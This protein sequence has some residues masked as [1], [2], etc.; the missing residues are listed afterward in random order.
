[1]SRVCN[2]Y[3]T[4]GSKFSCILWFVL[5][6]E[7]QAGLC[8]DR[9]RSG[10]ALPGHLD[11]RHSPRHARLQGGI[12]ARFPARRPNREQL[13]LVGDIV[14][15]WQLQ[16]SWYWPQSH[17]DVVQK[18]LRKARKGTEVIY[19]PGNHDEMLRRL[20]R[21]CS[22][23]GVQVAD[24][25]D[26]RDRRRPAAAGDPRRPVRRHR[27][28][29]AL[30]RAS[31][32]TRAYNVTLAAQPLLQ[33]RAPAARLS[34]LVAVG[35]PEAQGQERGRV[36]STDFEDAVADEAR[37]RGVDGVVCG[38]IHH[39]RDPRHRR[40]ALLQRRRLGRELHRAGRASRRA[41]RDH[42]TGWISARSIRCCA[43]VP[44]A[45]T[46]RRPDARLRIALVSDA[47]PPQINGVVR[48]LRHAGRRISTPPA[49]AVETMTPDRFRTIP[50]PSYPEIR[51][52]LKP[53]RRVARADRR[54]RAATP[55]TSPP[56][57]RSAWRR[58]ALCLKRGLPFTT[59]FH[60]AFPEYVAAR[61]A[62]PIAWG[63]AWLRRFHAPSH[64]VH[65]GHRDRAP[66]SRRPRLREAPALGPR[67][68]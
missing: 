13:Y 2:R 7:L 34:L 52:A 59:A 28:L 26:P 39:R 25:V 65:G 36:S 50:C 51:L 17:N 41:A 23:G 42:R 53:R 22:F 66:R 14:D 46:G 48:T 49:I 45:P 64:G 9:G 47:W 35:L 21:S 40:R 60:T 56:R 44:I 67:R 11:L 20:S 58:G 6:S 29:R 38:H 5:K 32:A 57:A 8:H 30:A 27:A 3:V 54:A 62:V 33:R 68:R 15:G 4:L 55:S 1:M 24:E 12:P 18:I 31:W 19:M 10:Q 37:K 61:F 16:R 63:Y 43:A